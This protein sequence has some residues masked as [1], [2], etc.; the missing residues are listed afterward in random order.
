MILF[1]N[2]K[3]NLGLHITG[4]RSDG[5]HNLETVFYPLPI[6]DALEVITNTKQEVTFNVTGATIEGS[7]ENICLK[8]YTLLKKDFPELP[9]VQMHLHKNIPVGAGLGGG[10][11]DGAFT[12][13]L[14]NKK[15]GLE[16][17]EQQLLQ[18]A[19]QLGSDCPFFILNKPCLG[20][21]R[22]EVL[23]PVDLDLSAYKIILINPGIHINTGRAFGQLTPKE[24]AMSLQEVIQ[25]PVAEWKDFLF[26]DFEDP[27]FKHHPAVK[28]V[29]EDL[30]AEGAVYASMSGSGS[31]VFGLFLK[32]QNPLFSF[33]PA[34]FVKECYL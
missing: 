2:C 22:G 33:P 21:G 6:T 14:L 1:P 24:A 30:F 19:L 11:A 5:F 26:N 18:Y 17:S 32:N 31:T 15:Y 7:G 28:K 29:K 13:L 10:S 25:K 9:P 34:Y 4:K 16:L 12:L 20:K 23:T 3:I 8:A 27:I